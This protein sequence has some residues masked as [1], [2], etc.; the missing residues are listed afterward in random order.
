VEGG[1]VRGAGPGQP[2]GHAR[3]AMNPHSIILYR[4]GR[5]TISVMSVINASIL[6]E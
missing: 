3:N 2:I 1:E 6:A 4:I 5:P